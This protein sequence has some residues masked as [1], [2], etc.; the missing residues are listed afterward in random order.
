MTMAP[1]RI[2]ITGAAGSGTSTLGR[3]LS[4]ATGA[5]HLDTDDYFWLPSDPPFQAQREVSERLALLE[6]AISGTERWVLTGS[7][8]RWGD[9]LIPQFDL[10]VFLLIPPALRMDRL[11]AREVERYGAETL[12]RGGAMHVAHHAFLDWA[13]AYDS[14]TRVGRNLQAHEAWLAALPC[15]VLR[16]EGDTTVEDRVRRVRSFRLREGK[17]W[18]G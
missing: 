13:E 6:A 5:L 12:A 3:A 9:S 2:H 11:R 14:G 4:T 7:L 8:M 1:R 15:P 17:A 16:I 18:R 10:V